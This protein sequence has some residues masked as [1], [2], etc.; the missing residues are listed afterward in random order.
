VVLGDP[1]APVAEPLD[2][3]YE[4]DRVAKRLRGLGALGDDREVE[5]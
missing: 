1:V 4:L 2:V 5:Y 3:L